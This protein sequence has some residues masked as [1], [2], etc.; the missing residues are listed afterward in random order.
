MRSFYFLGKYSVVCHFVIPKPWQSLG[1]FIFLCIIFIIFSYFLLKIFNFKCDKINTHNLKFIVTF[2]TI[3]FHIFTLLH[4]SFLDQVFSSLLWKLKSFLYISCIF[5]FIIQNYRNTAG[6]HVS[7][8][9]NFKIETYSRIKCRSHSLLCLTLYTLSYLLAQS[10]SFHNLWYFSYVEVWKVFFVYLG[11][12]TDTY[13]LHKL[14]FTDFSVLLLCPNNTS[15]KTFHEC[16]F[17][18]NLKKTL[19]VLLIL[20]FIL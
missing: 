19:I 3:H 18:Y 12:Y 10:Y 14:Y 9:K 15:R 6:I 5:N 1:C 8:N 17:K 13:S 20:F 11:I 7:Y 16:L 4:L 2:L